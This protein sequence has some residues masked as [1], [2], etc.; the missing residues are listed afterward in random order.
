VAESPVPTAGTTTAELAFAL[1]HEIANLVGAVR[2][3]AHLVDARMTTRELA[4]ASIEIDDLCARSAALLAHLR[5]LL[6]A[7]SEIT[8]PATPIDLI[9]G[10]RDVMTHHGGRGTQLDFVATEGLAPIA[11]DQEVLHYVLQSLLFAGL[12]AAGGRGTVG[13]SAR[14]EDDEVVFAV[15]DDGPV[16]EDPSAW[17]GQTARGRPLVCAVADAIV[18]KRGGSLEVTRAGGRT[19]VSVRIPAREGV[20]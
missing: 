3:H 17:R 9:N 6:D 20:S 7:P 14:A 16:D 12:E 18:G 1:C 2:I 10:L 5:P 15:E 11:I 4:R 13:L 8:R 19:L